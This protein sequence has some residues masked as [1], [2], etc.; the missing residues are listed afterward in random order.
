MNKH[1]R[2]LLLL[3]LIGFTLYQCTYDQAESPQPAF[4]SNDEVCD[5]L[6]PSFEDDIQPIFQNNCAISGCHDQ[7]SQADGKIWETYVQISEGV[8]NGEVL[9]AI[10]R[11]ENDCIPMPPVEYEPLTN[12]QIQ[13]IECWE[14]HDL[15][16][17]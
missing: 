9:C 17:N 15:P 12:R 3:A 4:S 2:V 7:G 13:M 11:N 6:F 5:T 14:E 10:K 8:D 1:L 16:N